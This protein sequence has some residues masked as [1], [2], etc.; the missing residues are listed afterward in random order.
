MVQILYWQALTLFNPGKE[1]GPGQGNPEEQVTPGPFLLDSHGHAFS[2]A[3]NSVLFFNLMCSFLLG[4]ESSLSFQFLILFA[5]N[6][7]TD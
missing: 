6:A 7:K 4:A 2:N 1:V 3:P 5:A